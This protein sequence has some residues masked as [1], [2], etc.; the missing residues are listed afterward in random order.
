MRIDQSASTLTDRFRTHL[1]GRSL[2]FRSR[3]RTEPRASAS[4]G[5]LAPGFPVR[6]LA[7]ELTIS[8][9]TRSPTAQAGRVRSFWPHQPHSATRSMVSQ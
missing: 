3:L 6:A 2:T 9:V 4:G 8:A 5:G 1:C 7:V